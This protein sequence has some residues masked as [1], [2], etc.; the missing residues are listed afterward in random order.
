MTTGIILVFLF[1]GVPILSLSLD[2]LLFS[3]VPCQ[4]L[5]FLI[6]AS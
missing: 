1:Q 4:E 2:T 5:L 3:P 6:S